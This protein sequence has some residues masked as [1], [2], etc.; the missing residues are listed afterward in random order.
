M[1]LIYSITHA[2]PYLLISTQIR[3]EN[4]PTT[5]GDSDSDTEL[6]SRVEA[7]LTRKPG[8]DFQEWITKWTPRRVL[9]AYEQ[10]GY[11]V[12]AMCGIGQTCAWTLHKES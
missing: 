2:M 1:L 11:R 6:M 5:V 12:I 3:L 4:G 8:N 7:V 9:D 10:D